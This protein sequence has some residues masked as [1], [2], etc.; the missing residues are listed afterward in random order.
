MND[1]NTITNK[2]TTTS[3]RAKYTLED[4]AKIRRLKE[5][6]LSWTAIAEHFPGRT[7]RAIEVRYHTKLKTTNV[8]R[9]G[10]SRRKTRQER[11]ESLDPQT[12]D[13]NSDEY[14]VDKIV[15]HRIVDDGSIEY[16]VLWVGKDRTS[17]PHTAMMNTA[18]LDT[19]LRS[20]L[21][22]GHGHG[23]LVDDR[24]M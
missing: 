23:L 11:D 16:D 4:G 10:G 21:S 18:A 22:M 1:K 15:C 9:S 14:D 7:S 13:D 17:E 8:S 5:E 24:V 2:P 12:S 6:G 3:K 20:C 19:Y